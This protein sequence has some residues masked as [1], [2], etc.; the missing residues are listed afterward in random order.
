MESKEIE[1]HGVQTVADTKAKAGIVTAYTRVEATPKIRTEAVQ[2][3]QRQGKRELEI[4]TNER[5]SVLDLAP[6]R[7]PLSLAL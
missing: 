3:L 1:L 7:S 5:R 6:R 4:P 2:D